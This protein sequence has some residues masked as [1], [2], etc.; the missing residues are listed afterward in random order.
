M[1]QQ[2]F[3]T[4][5][6]A[7]VESQL[8]TSN[9]NDP[10]VIR[11]ILALPRELFV[12][13]ERQAAAY[14]DRAVPL[15]N[16]RALNPPL[17]T[18]RL[19]VAANLTAGQTVLLIG[20]AT[21]YAAALLA[22]LGVQVVAVESDPALAATARERLAS[23]SAVTVVEGPLAAGHPASAPYDLLFID[24][25][26]E[27][28]PESL[29]EQVKPGGRAVFA[30]AESGVTRLCAGVRSTG[31]HGAGSFADAEA[32]ILPGFASPRPFQF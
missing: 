6:R 23:A 12:P 27:E 22:A 3:T 21:G 13:V 29:W 28:V 4:M 31:G 30:R 18:A 7:M 19:L 11:A 15:G 10:A 14:A 17:A 24:G 20:A 5:R 8:R 9:V 1:N 16:G 32:V 2:S 26:V 25:A